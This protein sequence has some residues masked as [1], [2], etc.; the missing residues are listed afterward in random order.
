MPKPI[1]I[2]GNQRSG[3]TWL[4]NILCQHSKIVGVQ[5]EPVG[6][7]ESTYF[8]LIEGFF[9]D[10]KEDNNFIQFIETF[11]SSD[12][13]RLTGVEKELF[14][15]KRPTTYVQTFQ[16]LMNTFTNKKNASYWLEKTPG[17]TLFL[18]KI[19]KYFMEAKFIGIKR[20][21]TDTIKSAVRRTFIRNKF[22][23][24]IFILR[25]VLQHFKYIKHLDKF[26]SNSKRIMIIY[27]KDLRSNR[28]KTL[29]KICSFLELD[30]EPSLLIDR[31][32]PNT[33]F[34]NFDKQDERSKILTSLDK[35]IIKWL[36]AILKIFPY[37]F[38]R[39]LYFFQLNVRKKSFPP[40]YWDNFKQ[41]YLI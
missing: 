23:K 16:L 36:S 13:F 37:R 35:K 34:T 17:H 4:A 10:I 22:I 6:I 31:Y 24:K 40:R 19:S 11:G 21:T 7:R 41:E 39:I 32:R 9:G 12:Y 33:S 26:K 8:N 30:F 27:Y 38:Y 2:V 25:R 29:A 14:Y 18:P 28:Q 1:F 5:G 3:T 15:K 20:D